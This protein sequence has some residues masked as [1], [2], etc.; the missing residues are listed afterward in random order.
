MTNSAVTPARAGQLTAAQ[1]RLLESRIRATAPSAGAAPPS[2][3]APQPR[4]QQDEPAPLSVAQERPWYFSRL[5]PGVPVF[6]EAVTIRKDGVFDVDAFRRAFTE[7]VHRHEAWRTTFTELDAG[8]VQIVHPPSAVDVPL[9]DLSSLAPDA[10]LQE[11]AR[12]AAEVAREPY[13][14][15]AGPLLRPMLVRFTD[16]HHRLYLAMHHLV[17]DGVSLYRTVLP[18][19]VAL[20]DAFSAGKPSPLSE[21]AVRYTDYV[22]AERAWVANA[23]LRD[24]LER[25]RSLASAPPLELP[26][27]HP[28]PARQQFHGGMLAVEVPKVTVEGLR[29]IGQQNGATLFQ[30]LGAAFGVLLSRYSGQDDIVFGTESDARRGTEWS[31][32]VGY[33]LTPLLIRCQL[34][35]DPSFHEL[36]ARVRADVVSALDAP[37]PFDWLV[38]E[39]A[40]PRVGVNRLFQAMLILEPP[41]AAVDPE[42]S[43]HQMEAGIGDAI[44]HAKLDL[45]LEL[46]ERPDGHLAGRVIYDSDLF[47]R[48]T[49]ERMI[50]HWLTLLDGVLAGPDQPVSTLPVLTE[51]EQQQFADWNATQADYPHDGCLHELIEACRRQSPDEVAVR[52]NGS[53]LTYAELDRWSDRVAARLQAAD[54]GPGQVVAFHAHRS[55]EM[56][57]GLVGILKSGAAYLPL[58]PG[59]PPDR[60]SYMLDDSGAVVLLTAGDAPALP[61]APGKRVA[62]PVR[63][64]AT[65]DERPR[66]AAVS[67]EDPA[68]VLYT[69][70]STGR[71][72]GVRVP[73]RA[74]VNL[75]S[76]MALEPGM[77]ASDV[78]VAVTTHAFDI[79]VVELLLPLTV[80]ARVVVA[81]REQ[82]ADGRLLARLLDDAGATILQATPATWEALLEAGWAGRPSL[83]ALCGGESL[84][85]GVAAALLERCSELW[86][87]YGPTETTVW[88]T[89][90][91]VTGSDDVTI[92]RPIANTRVYVLGRHGEQT[93]VGVAGE[94]CIG[95]DGVAK[96]YLGRPELTRERFVPEPGH[97]GE[98]MYRTGDVVTFLPDGRLRHLGRLDHQIKLRG[99]RIEPGEI[100]AALLGQPGVSSALVVAS[101]IGVAARL[102][103]YVVASGKR[104][105]A[106]EMRTRLRSRLPDYMVPTAIVALETWPLNGSGK[107]DRAALPAPT[108]EARPDQGGRAVP[109][110]PLEAQLCQAFTKTLRVAR[111]GIDDDFFELGGHSLLAVRLMT[112]VKRRTGHDLRLA[113]L[114]EVGATPARLAAHLEPSPASSPAH[115]PAALADAGTPPLFFIHPNQPSLLT[116]R[117]FMRA[118][119][120]DQRIVGM[121]PEQP[122]SGS[123]GGGI[124]EQ[125]QAL[126]K[127][128]CTS[129][130]HGPYLVAGYSRGG[131]LAY[132]VARLLIEAG[133]RVAFVGLVD[134]VPPSLAALLFGE[135]ARQRF[136]RHWLAGRRAFLRACGEAIGD[137]SRA[138]RARMPGVRRQP[139]YFDRARV[140]AWL[141]DYDIA[142]T[143][144]PVTLF[145][146][147]DPAAK[148]WLHEWQ[149]FHDGPLHVHQVPG[150]HT[151]MVLQPNVEVLAATVAESV[152]HALRDRAELV[153]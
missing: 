118:L 152:R 116:L 115:E 76:S 92:G 10:A 37:V 145:V 38:Q 128:I 24:N 146:S 91:R 49:A 107:I 108:F 39:L 151:T 44:G 45:S 131:L 126:L 66:R 61:G 123:A 6:N 114:F 20:Y 88:S 83:V 98:L 33:C 109:V 138:L 93:P 103:G 35:D 52:F 106:G 1:R 12:R 127:S 53:H 15:A 4:P 75:V 40:G 65:A 11:A 74:V 63:L 64:D 73:H 13:D 148:L 48:Q 29:G 51:Q 32:L 70:G 113:A 30:V 134:T 86:N 89:L 71:P 34:A 50:G 100:E 14:L 47:D 111:V 119:P 55:L 105:D 27:D 26:T 46:D 28:R 3:M 95:G 17:F 147:E 31:S 87:C 122:H 117:H 140:R 60:L 90:A 68:Y 54:V 153:G 69:S 125:S 104:V 135:T 102:V 58:D 121:L 129:Q 132:E 78:V 21:P 57:V 137:R 22:R 136:V 96:G 142:A 120:S 9:V 99:F 18:E 143:A 112:E 77:D 133:E 94:L 149:A 7:L 36:L 67:P 59:H 8:P 97:P 124:A 139:D 150:G 84:A 101:G 144:A 79:S 62:M 82:A 56:V 41:L 16:S 23:R 85:P 43:L 19:L 72:K 42:W 25:W 130:P 2:V 80:G 141:K 5:A 81:S 110:T